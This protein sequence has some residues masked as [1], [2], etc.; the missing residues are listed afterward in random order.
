MPNGVK[1]ISEAAI[2]R[3]P[4]YL[5]VFRN[6]KN[7]GVSH[8]SSREI[9]VLMGVTASQ[10]RQDFCQFGGFGQQGYGYDTSK[11]ETEL[12]AILGLNKNHNTVIFGAGN[13]GRALANYRP[14]YEKGFIITALFDLAQVDGGVN[15]IPVYPLGKFDEFARDNTVD[16]AVI[17]TPK[18]CAADTLNL[19][20]SA[21][22]KNVWNFAPVELKER[23]DII[24]ENISMS[25]SLY[26]LSYKLD[27]RDK[28]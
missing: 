10:V 23:G 20:V 16:I 18:E 26:V 3:L 17:A 28:F 25:D 14:F 4:R 7:D 8:I 11:L 6:L 24:I 1:K 5:R 15:G 12:T 9:A 22:I 2:K 13:I 27:N 19:I 21:G